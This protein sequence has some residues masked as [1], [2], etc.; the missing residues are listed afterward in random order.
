MGK[1]GL[2]GAVAIATTAALGVIIK[3]YN[4]HKKAV[5][6]HLELM[7]RMSEGQQNL[8]DIQLAAKEAAEQGQLDVI[9]E[10]ANEAVKQVERLS[11]AMK[12]LASSE[13]AAMGANFNLHIAKINEEFSKALNEASEELKP[14]VEA[15]KNLAIALKRQEDART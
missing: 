12:A 11:S 14:V 3:A 13:D 10:K 2:I 15:E 4:E 8:I 9:A 7:R 6:D 5:E 1:G